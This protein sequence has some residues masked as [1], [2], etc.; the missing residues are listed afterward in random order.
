MEEL[1][2]MEGHDFEYAVADLLHHNGYRDVSVTQGSGDY[3]IDVLARRKNVKYAIQC[4]RYN[5]SVG[6]KAV[7]EAGLGTDFYHCDAAAVITNSTFTKQATNLANVTG[8]RLWGRA[9]LED[10]IKNYDEEYGE[11]RQTGSINYQR[12]QINQEK[13]DDVSNT[14]TSRCHIEDGDEK[15]HKTVQTKESRSCYGNGMRQKRISRRLASEHMKRNTGTVEMSGT[16]KLVDNE[17]Y[18]MNDVVSR[19]EVSALRKFLLLAGWAMIIMGM[20]LC[21]AV[22]IPGLLSVISGACFV[23]YSIKLNKTLRYQKKIADE[24]KYEP[25]SM[26]EVCNR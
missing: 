1:D 16:I 5:G 4:K 21:V 14:S 7:Q 17:I 13:V 8:V 10:L 23:S 20:I 18:L 19:V 25:I 26:H 2:K 22:I 12:L 24:Q 6:V 3:G 9:F 15:P 11:I